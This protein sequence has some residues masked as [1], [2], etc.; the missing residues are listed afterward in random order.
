M[1]LFIFIFYLLGHN[2]YPA[3]LYIG[4][5]T[6]D[7][8]DENYQRNLDILF[9]HLIDVKCLCKRDLAFEDICMYNLRKMKLK[10]INPDVCEIYHS[11]DFMYVLHKLY[12][13]VLLG[14]ALQ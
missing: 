8:R 6:R 4:L 1:Y 3:N 13:C 11:S 14:I 2:Y 9:L 5:C 12:M 10:L 7:V